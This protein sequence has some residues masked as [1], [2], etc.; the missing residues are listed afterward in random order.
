MLHRLIFISI[1]LFASNFSFGQLE[2]K[3]LDVETGQPVPGVVIY[4]Q[5]DQTLTTTTGKF[6][7]DPS[8][9]GYLVFSHLGYQADTLYLTGDTDSL[10]VYLVPDYF[11]LNQILIRGP[12]LPH[13]IQSIPS[14][15]SYLLGSEVLLSG[16]ATVM[17]GLNQ[18]PGVYVHS[19]AW[20]TNRVTIRGIGS[21]TPYGTNRIRAYY[22]DIP[23]TTG[24][25]TTV[26]EDIDPSMIHSVEVVKGAKSALYGSG[27]GGIILLNGKKYLKPGLHGHVGMETGMFGTYQPDAN[28]QYR[29]GNLSLQAGYAFTH[30]DGWR[31]NSEYRRHNLFFNA[32]LEQEKS[33]TQ[34][35]LNYIDLKAYIPSSLSQE[36]FQIA[37]DSAANNWLS[38]KGFEEYRKLLTGIRHVRE[39]T[40]WLE[41]STVV[42]LN[43]FDGYELRPF[44]ILDDD[45]VQAGVRSHA[46]FRYRNTRLKIGFE[47]VFE[48]YNWS[49]YDT[50]SGNFGGLINQFQETRH[51]FHL[52][53]QGGYDFANGGNIEAGI[54]FNHLRHCSKIN[55]HS[56][57]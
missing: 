38:A 14:S 23:L 11:Q 27:L 3:V 37:P 7:L 49:I 39:I 35:L 16:K 52:F 29:D 31:Q 21:R 9:Y 8:T 28:I 54:S 1:F 53:L 2:G 26:I 13:K 43:F 18:V 5:G 17:E 32:G 56:L 57:C 24:D 30:T 6:S 22:N 47:G 36:T 46:G 44:N 40:S 33:S 50:D 12:L 19:G 45:A 55:W 25:G 15:I 41:S 34:L 20:N 51:P 42:Y 48:K 4:G 10:M